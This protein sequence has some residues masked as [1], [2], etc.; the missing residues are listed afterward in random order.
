MS[1]VLTKDQVREEVKKCGRDPTYFITNYCKIAHPE[2]GLIPFSLY[3]YQQDTIKAF[4]DYRFNIVLKA[5]QLGLSTA[6]AGYI[7]WMLLFRRQK[8]VLVVATKLD[9]AANLV[10]KVKKMIKSLPAWMNIADISI[11]NRNSFELNNGSWIKASS[12]SESAGRSEALSLLVIDEAAFVEGMEDLW[13][14][15][16]PTL[17]AITLYISSYGFRRSISFCRVFILLFK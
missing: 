5:R 16:F 3:G 10:K 7:A 2:K 17:S 4:E 8:T 13:K 12:T 11:D 15:I 14:S 1:Y 9:V 6:V